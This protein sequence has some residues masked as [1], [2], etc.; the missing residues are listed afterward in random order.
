M[1]TEGLSDLSMPAVYTNS[2]YLTLKCNFFLDGTT[3]Q[4]DLHLLN[5]LLQVSSLCLPLF[6]AFNFAFISICLY[7]I[8]PL[9]FGHSLSPLS[10]GL[11]INTWPTLLL[12]LIL[13]TRPIQFNNIIWQNETQHKLS[14]LYSHGGATPSLWKCGLCWADSLSPGWQM[15]YHGAVVKWK[16]TGP[17]HSW[18]SQSL[19][20]HCGD[21][22]SLAIFFKQQ[23][24]QHTK[25]SCMFTSIIFH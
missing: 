18:G 12:L 9:L 15:N 19:A 22:Y 13:L 1:N 2:W 6:S 20:R 5:G 17:C 4:C 21:L 7:T 10:W 11:C 16:L 24:L 23:I 3:V 8:P 25:G 14:I